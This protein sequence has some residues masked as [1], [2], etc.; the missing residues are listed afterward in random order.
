[1]RTG[2][3]PVKRDFQQAQGGVAGPAVISAA[4]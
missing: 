4:R 3:P 2:L 1:M